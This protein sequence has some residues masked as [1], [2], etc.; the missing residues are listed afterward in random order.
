MIN[1]FKKFCL[2]IK[3]TYLFAVASIQLLI[4]LAALVGSFASIIMVPVSIACF[5][6]GFHT[7][8]T[9]LMFFSVS[10]WTL[11]FVIPYTFKASTKL[12]QVSNELKALS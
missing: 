2:E 1:F 11:I 12:E 3:A 8:A 9:Y 5:Y 4:S 6:F 10:A 7:V